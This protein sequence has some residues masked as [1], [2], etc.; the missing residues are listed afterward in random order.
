MKLGI[1][2]FVA[3]ALLSVSCTDSGADHTLTVFAAASLVDPFTEMGRLFEKENPGTKVRFNFLASS[4]LAAQIELGAKADVFASADLSNARR[5]AQALEMGTPRRFARN[6]LAIA[7]AEGN[8]LEIQ[9]LT[10]LEDDELVISICNPECPAG[11]YALEVFRNAGVEVKPDSF[12]QAATGVVVRVSLGEA[13]AG[14]A[15]VTDI[16]G[17]TEKVDAVTIPPR[18]NV[19]AEYM[20]LELKGSDSAG[21]FVDLVLS[22]EGQEI[23]RQNG[24]ES[25]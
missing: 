3:S 14:I 15:Y 12:E 16:G 6:R 17:T 21:E 7:V 2:L 23:L 11:R 8:P 24:F 5:V 10:D 9:S 19:V 20:L 22:P 13:D 4:E 1:L 25:R 18:H